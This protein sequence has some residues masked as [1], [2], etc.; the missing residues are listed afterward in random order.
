MTVFLI[1]AVLL[2]AI[3]LAFVLPP[4]LRKDED[5]TRQVAR[6]DLN[7]AVLRDQLRE[8]DADLAEGLIEQAAYESAR[9]DLEQRVAEEVQPD[10]AIQMS[11]K[12]NR[13]V[14]IAIGV[15]VPALAI[16]IYLALGSPDALDPTQ[17]IAANENAHEVTP[18]QVEA[19]V[20][21][22][23]ERLRSKPDDV[24]GWNILARS[25]AAMGRYPEASKA[26]AHL[27]TLVPN[28]AN[29]LVDYADTL[30]MSLGKSL[31]GEPEKM[32]ARAL[33]IDPK[34]I[35]ALSLAGSAA[36]ERREYA[37]AATQWR[38]ILALV[39][40]DS[41]TAQSITA[42]INEAQSLSGQPV[43]PQPPVAQAAQ[44]GAVSATAAQP[45]KAAGR[46]QGT[47]ELDPALR[48]QVADTD[49]VF[50]FARAANGPPFPLAVLRKQVKDLPTAF[51]LDDEMSMMPDAKISSF[52]QV[53]VGAR[54]S[55]SG[56]AKPEAG[57]FEGLTGAVVPGT[58]NVNVIIKT[59]R[60]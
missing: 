47:V 43:S 20:A 14:A 31:Q 11:G 48:G 51:S 53:V 54:I 36:F 52:P 35:K 13:A 4:L 18:A 59:R 55:K 27:I 44:G 37:N 23:A 38:K 17:Q 32:V 58:G 10:T 5:N 7:L 28:D 34:N 57:D 25:Y 15:A 50:I 26:Y 9:H 42:S 46:I 29:L 22:L 41:E 39:P 49:V 40:A 8:L 6:D 21:G 16:S 45:G 2:A 19:M 56:N 60:Q 30:A 1:G 12:R 24:N 33:Q 3:A